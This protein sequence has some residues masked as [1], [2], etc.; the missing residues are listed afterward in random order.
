MAGVHSSDAAFRNLELRMKIRV[1]KQHRF[2]FYFLFFL[3]LSLKC[4]SALPWTLVIWRF[5]V[6][7][8]HRK[9]QSSD[10]WINNRC[11]KCGK[12]SHLILHVTN[13]PAIARSSEIW[14]I[15]LERR[16]CQRF[17]FSLTLSSQ[18]HISF[19]SPSR[20]FS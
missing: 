19:F 18:S 15:T 7:F 16:S 17:I 2:L 13:G 20:L 8:L 12:H 3:N 9:C 5:A 1:H 10:R 14:G 6:S 11:V 4:A